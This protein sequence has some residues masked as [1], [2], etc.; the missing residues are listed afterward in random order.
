LIN[1]NFEFTTANRILFGP[2]TL[3]EV[4]SIAVN[5]GDRALLVIGR[6]PDRASSLVR[7]LESKG[8]F[9][10]SFNVVSEPTLETVQS[11]VIEAKENGCEF[12]VGLGGGSVIDTGKAIAAV[13]ANKGDLLDY[14]EVIGE[15]RLL[16]EPSLPYIAIPTTA[17]TGSEVTR[18]AVLTS[19]DHRVKVSLRSPNMLPRLAV[20]DPELT[21]SLPPSITAT[22]GLDALTQLLEPYLCN[23]P[24]PLTDALCREGIRRV[25]LSIRRACLDGDDLKARTDMSLASLFSGM[26][27]ANAKLGAVHGL[28]G[29]LGGVLS[30]PHGAIC[31]RLLPFVMETNLKSL[32][33]RAPSSPILLRYFAV[34]RLLTGREAAVPADGVLWIHSLCKEL[35]IPTLSQQGLSVQMIPAIANQ[36]IRTSSMKGNP[37]DLNDLELSNILEQAL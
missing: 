8:I 3:C 36:A 33:K 9:V 13:L 29:P 22:T 27:L 6:S 37:I 1:M 15:G 30:A 12:I 19:V 24:N 21:C 4:A 32:Q 18:N 25:A 17:G 11:G 35:E 7:Q 31:A 34:A 23:S 14:L 20:V 16:S 10:F 26:A 5:L 28:A 2:G